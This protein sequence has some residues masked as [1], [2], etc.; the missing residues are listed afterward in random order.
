MTGSLGPPENTVGG[1]L[2]FMALALEALL[3]SLAGTNLSRQLVHSS[4][5]FLLAKIEIFSSVREPICYF[6][7]DDLQCPSMT[8]QQNWCHMS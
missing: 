8:S 4:D 1:S 3:C 6:R 7:Y 5:Q 2:N